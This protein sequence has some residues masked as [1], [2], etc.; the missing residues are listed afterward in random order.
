M[1][2]INA[3]PTEL[4]LQNAKE[5][6]NIQVVDGSGNA[7]DAD[8]VQLRVV[9]MGNK[10]KHIDSWPGPYQL[11]G[12]LTVA[13]GQTTVVGT[14]TKFKEDV[15]ANTPITFG[16]ETHT[17]AQIQSDTHLIL[18]TSHVAGAS[19]ATATKP[20]RIVADPTGAGRYYIDWG[21]PTAPANV[22]KQSETNVPC[23]VLFQW[24]IDAAS[25]EQDVA[26]QVL[27]IVTPC[28]LSFLPGFRLVIDK[29][30]KAVNQDSGC[31]LGYTDAQ[32]IQYLEDGLT[33]INAYEPYPVFNTLDHFPRQFQYILFES[34]LIA[35]VMS[36][37]LF[38]IDTDIPNY[39]DQGNTFVIQHGPQL[40][41]VLNQ[42]S[43][44]LDKIIPL[45]KL[46]FVQS[47]SL[48]VQAGPNYRLAQL[49]NAA[50]NGALFRNLFFTS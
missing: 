27:K 26:V 5:R 45:M 17:I 36:Q 40:A 38:A 41:N 28:T 9:D 25:Y 4:A 6:V 2:V 49:L 1:T 30:V 34:S 24:T 21:D 47:G 14:N 50:P 29:A 7:M 31:F 43:Q 16:G 44:R 3:N 32:L 23:D 10:V 22:D 37:Q 20:T 48:H 39:S 8:Q 46:K 13:A 12:T 19:G 15:V 33:I 35:G 18:E 11:R 42:I